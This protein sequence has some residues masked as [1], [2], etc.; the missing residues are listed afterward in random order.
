MDFDAADF[1]RYRLKYGDILLNEGQSHD[2][3]GRPAMWRDEVD[4][5][6]F[7]NTLIRF[8]AN[9]DKTIPE[10]ALAVFLAYF[11][12]GRFAAVGSQTSNVA[13]LGATRFA[14]MPFPL[15]PLSLQRIFAERIAEVRSAESEQFA[16]KQGL[17]NLF[18]SLLTRAFNGELTAAW[19]ERHAELLHDE[20]VQR[21][22][23]L[24]LRAAEPT[25]GD[26][27]DDRVTHAERAEAERQLQQ[28]NELLLQSRSPFLR[29][30]ADE[31]FGNLKETLIDSALAIATQ[32]IDWDAFQV[33]V[34][35]EIRIQVAQVADSFRAIQQQVRVQPVLRQS[36]ELAAQMASALG[37]VFQLYQRAQAIAGSRA[38]REAFDRHAGALIDKLAQVPT[39]FRAEDL[40]QNGLGIS[41]ADEGLRLLAAL[42]Y[43]RPVLVRGQERY[44]RVDPISERV[45]IEEF[46]E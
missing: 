35:E 2:L 36:P 28:A 10:F 23:A 38:V 1:R 8:R 32:S 6:C 41:E 44:R 27:E 37:Q 46:A 45:V 43:V 40:A 24:G 11:R 30:L 17:D 4:D 9:P 3:V 14:Q 16:S 12:A 26:L 5:C 34:P 33:G 19:R 7:Q 39:Y 15:P 18:Q 20:A 13:H 31:M 29:S 25:L 21:D 22:I 42:G